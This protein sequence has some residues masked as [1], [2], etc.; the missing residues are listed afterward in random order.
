MR[1]N[2]EDAIL[3]IFRAAVSSAHAGNAVRKVLSCSGSTVRLS[4]GSAANYNLSD[5]GRLFVVGAGKAAAAMAS[6]AEEIL[7]DLIRGGVIS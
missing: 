5:K 2:H 1:E 7:G 3:D 6:A 4:C